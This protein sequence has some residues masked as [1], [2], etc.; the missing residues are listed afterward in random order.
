MEEN[1][2]KSQLESL[3]KDTFGDSSEYIRIVFD[4]YFNPDLA[5][6][7]IHNN[8]VISALYGVPYSFSSYSGIELRGLYLC[9]LATKTD[10]RRKGLMSDLIEKINLRALQA[11][12]DFT[13]L[14]PENDGVRKF[15]SDRRYHNSFYKLKEYFV[16][17]H[18]FA[19]ESNP[20]FITV[21]LVSLKT[22]ENQNKEMFSDYLKL[23]NKTLD[24]LGSVK[25][26]PNENQFSFSILHTRRDWELVIDEAILSGYKIFIGMKNEEIAGIAFAVLSLND[27]PGAKT[28]GG[29]KE[30]H[31]DILIKKLILSRHEESGNFINSIGLIY[32][33]FNFII[34]K[35]AVEIYPGDSNPQLWSPFF[36]IHN[37]PD[38]QYQDISHT[39]ETFNPLKN[40]FPFG[41]IRFLNIDSFLEKI[42]LKNKESI[43][44]FTSSEIETVLLR[45]PSQD[46]SDDLLYNMLDIPEI[47]FSASLLLE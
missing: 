36:A 32:P 40:A 2:I 47:N 29:Q 30:R 33:E 17:D 31:Q 5:V 8:E 19:Q 13:F 14:I 38:S 45:K 39:E 23:R 21:D 24:F 44:G 37:K 43:K 15:Y 16:Y 25:L 26:H 9:G 41:M 1:N 6:W 4:N 46:A 18:R 42:G 35:D 12:F 34:I 27:I 7:H 28:H 22:R 3:W 20:E 11:G 10:F